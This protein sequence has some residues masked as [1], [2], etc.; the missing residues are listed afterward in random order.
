GRQRRLLRRPARRDF[1]VPGAERRRQDHHHQDAHHPVAPDDGLARARRTRCHQA[2]EGRAHAVRRRVPGSES[3]QRAHGVGEHGHPRG[4]VPRAA[5]P[6]ADR[7]STRLNSSHL[8]ISYAV[9]CLK[10]KKKN[11]IRYRRHLLHLYSY[12]TAPYHYFHKRRQRATATD[13]HYFPH[14]YSIH[15]FLQLSLFHLRL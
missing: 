10:K 14:T 3:R 15:Q 13:F 8:V 12:I 4:A 2:S 7:K 11:L 5:A 9:F 6:P 1:R